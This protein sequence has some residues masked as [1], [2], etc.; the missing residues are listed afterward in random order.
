[1]ILNFSNLTKDQQIKLSSIYHDNKNNLEKIFYNL[2]QKDEKN[3]L[4][5]SC[6]TSRHP[7][8]NNL[9]YKFAAIKLIE[10]YY[11]KKKLKKI[12]TQDKFLTKL[13]K[14]KFK[15]LRVIN[16]YPNSFTFKNNL[17]IFKNLFFFIKLYLFKN[18][19][20]KNFFLD[21]KRI[22]LIDIFLI[23]SMFYGSKF[24]NRYYSSYFKNFHAKDK[25][26]I[27]YLPIFFNRSLTR[28]NMK[29]FSTKNNFILHTDFLNIIDFF[30]II[31]RFITG[32]FF[33]IKKDVIYKNLNL[34]DLIN[35]EIVE[36]KFSHASLISLLN[37]YTFKKLKIVKADINI[38]IDWFENQLVDKSLNFSL[39]KFFPKTKSRG[40]FGINSDLDINNFLVPSKLEK[41]FNLVPKEIFIINK[42]QKRYFKKVYKNN[43]NLI[44]AF[45][46]QN[47]FKYLKNKKK[48]NLYNYNVLVVFTAS[49]LDNLAMIKTINSLSKELCNSINFLLRFHK[50]S[51]RKKILKMIADKVKFRISSN[52]SIYK[53][54]LKSNCVISRPGTILLEAKIFDVPIILTPRV[55]GVLPQKLNSSLKN[56]FCYENYE[57]E[58]KLKQLFKLRKKKNIIKKKLAE[59]SFTRYNYSKASNLIS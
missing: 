24:D 58:K 4:V 29:I 26:R 2:I 25:N 57:V 34:S 15:N 47:I 19:K 14:K 41:K 45:R 1:M 28:K 31:L 51:K 55:Y 7:E 23:E 35:Y 22:I 37:Y 53:L 56:S 38:F 42:D 44:P 33:Y 52:E 30:K 59:N 50:S 3:F 20:R 32:N 6:L 10:Y 39:S 36:K 49:Y 12:I 54:L 40:Y 21:K 48:N 11:K 13:I 9:Y 16:N 8:E 18:S 43:L 46:N 5:F 17:S 27:F